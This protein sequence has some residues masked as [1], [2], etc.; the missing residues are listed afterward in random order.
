MWEGVMVPK[1]NISGF[2]TAWIIHIPQRIEHRHVS[3]SIEELL[4]TC[5]LFSENIWLRQLPKVVGDQV[6]SI[7]GEGKVFDLRACD[8][9]DCSED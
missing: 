1:R 7:D 2:S 6:T 3:K 8:F 9:R 5:K 4:I